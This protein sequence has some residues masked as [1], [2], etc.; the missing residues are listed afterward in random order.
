MSPPRYH[1]TILPGHFA[2]QSIHHPG[3][4][5]GANL[6]SISHRC[7]LFEA[8]FLWE[9]TKETIDLPLGC[10]QGGGCSMISLRAGGCTCGSASGP[11]PERRTSP[12]IISARTAASSSVASACPSLRAPSASPALA[13]QEVAC[14]VTGRNDDWRRGVGYA[15]VWIGPRS[16]KALVHNRETRLGCNPLLCCKPLATEESTFVLAFFE[17]STGAEEQNERAGGGQQL[18]LHLSATPQRGAR[19]LMGPAAC[20]ASTGSP[21]EDQTNR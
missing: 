11:L 9:L 12:L 16:R 7:Y 18:G 5:P 21:L 6:K 15:R 14:W 10:L 20:P 17:F 19:R 13:A 8:A 3:G 2:E 4:N 1:N